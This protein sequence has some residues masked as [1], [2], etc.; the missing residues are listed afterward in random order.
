MAIKTGDRVRFLNAKGGGVVSKII[1][2]ELIEVTDE[3]GF[4]IPTLIRECVVIESA[5][6]V[7][8]SPNTKEKKKE[9]SV[10]LEEIFS[11]EE[12]YK[13]QEE[14]PEGENLN[15]WLAYL[16]ADIKTLSI[17]SYECYLINDSN[18]YLGYN[19]ANGNGTRFMSRATGFIQPNTKILLEEVKKEMLNDLEL[20]N[21][22]L[23]AFKREKSYSFRPAYDVQL[24]I[25]PVKFYKLHSFAEN[26]FFDEKALLFGIVRNNRAEDKNAVVI[27][28]DLPQIIRQKEHQAP[29]KVIKKR[30]T[31]EV[32]EVDLHIHQLLDNL[33]G[34]TNADMLKFQLE[35]FNETM[36]EYAKRKGQKIV[37]IHGKGDGVLRNEILKQLKSKYPACYSQDASFKE[38]GFGATMVTIK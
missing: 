28:E 9:E 25:N 3:D 10:K 13:P 23:F 20:L 37:F 5:G 7:S 32:I 1:S 4:D 22:Q 8:S 21:V 12:D 26:D 16:P 30:E 19:I 15:V 36:Q 17:T 11:G 33:N 2:K 27:P 29:A 31:P 14:T 34:L 38:Y 35:K 24:K 6:N 18:Y